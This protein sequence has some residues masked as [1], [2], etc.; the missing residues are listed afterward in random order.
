M[1]NSP[2]ISI[3]VATF[4]EAENLAGL[5]ESVNNQTY[6]NIEIMIIDGDSA[7]NTVELLE[8]HDQQIDY[9]ISE[10]DNG[11]YDAWNKALARVTGEYICFIGADDR[12][13]EPE[14]L[15]KVVD[16]TGPR[17][18]LVCAK[19]EVF[20][21][22]HTTSLAFGNAWQWEKLRSGMDLSHRGMLHHRS[23]FE[24]HGTYDDSYQIA[25]DY[26]FLLRCGPEL[27]AVFLNEVTI[28]AGPDGVSFREPYRSLK[29]RYMAQ[30][31]HR[32]VSW[33]KSFYMFTYDNSHAQYHKAK[34]K[35]RRILSFW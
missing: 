19:Y 17:V 30:R 2:K 16:L 14:S 27:K 6:Q 9:W 31:M 33:A 18:E 34:S 13:Y 24:R 23:L 25:G 4:N 5:I 26:E 20:W 28:T 3:V 7:D 35:I 11:I 8:Q 10:P 12:W 32:T 29:E 1:K 15:E 21:P 22:G